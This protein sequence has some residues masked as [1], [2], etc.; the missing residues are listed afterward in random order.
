MGVAMHVSTIQKSCS[1]S[2]VVIVVYSA[3]RVLRG[4]NLMRE[5]NNNKVL[6]LFR[7]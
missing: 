2:V 6:K 1:N 5:K 3:E 7:W 4:L